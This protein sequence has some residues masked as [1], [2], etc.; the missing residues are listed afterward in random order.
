MF[1]TTTDEADNRQRIVDVDGQS[2]VLREYVGNAP[3]RGIYVEGNEVND[4]DLPQGFLVTQPPSSVTRP[5]FHEAN[6]FQVFV[7]GDGH[8]GKKPAAPLTVQYA[9]ARTPYGPI[10]AG[11]RGIRYFTL[12]QR[13]D[14]GAKYMPEMR[15]KLVRG[16]QRQRMAP[17]DGDWTS[18]RDIGIDG[19]R[20]TSILAAE[21]DGLHAA[22]FELGPDCTFDMPDAADGGGQYH[23]V[24]SGALRGRGE[25]TLDRW[26]C[27]YAFPND[28][29]VRIQATSRG[30]AV[31]LLR[32]PIVAEAL[33][34][35]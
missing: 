2:Y 19:V 17:V 25:E 20:E 5:H 9:N 16:N 7:D 31:L 11:P 33:M 24:V 10:E 18:D 26:S 30:A 32:F 3:K 4:N 12:R 35:A 27:Q 8:F 34:Q 21:E 15:D 6:Q 23:V 1:E 13:W 29:T 22:L 28:G 14:P